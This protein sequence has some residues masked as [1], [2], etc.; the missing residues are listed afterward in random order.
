[1]ATNRFLAD[2]QAILIPPKCF[3]N[4]PYIVVKLEAIYYIKYRRLAKA[5]LWE[6]LL[7]STI[8]KKD[9]HD[10]GIQDELLSVEKAIKSV[11][12]AKMKLIEKMVD[13]SI[14]R[15]SFKEQ[16][17]IY[18]EEIE[19]LSLRLEA[20]KTTASMGTDV[21]KPKME[22]IRSIMDVGEL[23]EDIWNRF[24]KEVKVY[25]DKSLQIDWKFNEG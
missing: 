7:Y 8:S 2:P 1:M 25:S 23:T 16:K 19:N 5:E 13:R 18:D 9:K 17:K 14:D 10:V 12:N 15:N 4:A 20:L 6:S 21:D 24:V 11:E 3:G 22:E